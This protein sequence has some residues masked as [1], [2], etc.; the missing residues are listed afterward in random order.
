[1]VS[2]P[3]FLS[4]ARLQVD[5]PITW[6][7]PCGPWVSPCSCSFQGHRCSLKQSHLFGSRCITFD[8]ERDFHRFNW[9]NKNRVIRCCTVSINRSC[10]S[11][12]VLPSVY[13][14]RLRPQLLADPPYNLALHGCQVLGQGCSMAKFLALGPFTN[15][16]PSKGSCHI[17][18]VVITR[19]AR[20]R[21]IL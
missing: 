8:A 14:V 2:L 13:H 17:L 9:Q 21:S 7:S 6:L 12:H 3:N 20:A 16:V 1:M 11:Y 10:Q 4:E 18:R 19:T 5:R 15:A